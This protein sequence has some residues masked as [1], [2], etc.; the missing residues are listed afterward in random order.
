MKCLGNKVVTPKIH[1]ALKYYFE[2]NP[3]TVTSV[4]RMFGVNPQY[5]RSQIFRVEIMNLQDDL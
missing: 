1:E 4:A 5:L 3:K 2:N